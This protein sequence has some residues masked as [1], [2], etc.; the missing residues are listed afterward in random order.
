MNHLKSTPQIHEARRI[1]KAAAVQNLVLITADQG[2]IAVQSLDLTAAAGL[3]LGPAHWIIIDD[4]EV[5]LTTDIT[6]DPS[7]RVAIH[8]AEALIIAHDFRISRIHEVETT[9][10]QEEGHVEHI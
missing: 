9:T 3:G 2:G 7:I 1:V 6:I 5:D 4:Q 10:C 8:V